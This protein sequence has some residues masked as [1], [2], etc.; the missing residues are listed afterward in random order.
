[1]KTLNKLINQ[2]MFIKTQHKDFN[3]N[4]QHLH[5]IGV[6]IQLDMMHQKIKMILYKISFLIYEFFI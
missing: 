2:I 6:M 3:K 4:N 1:M 5:I